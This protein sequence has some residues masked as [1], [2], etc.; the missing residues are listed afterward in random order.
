MGG[1]E[2]IWNSS[3]NMQF[4]FLNASL[5]QPT[6]KRSKKEKKENIF[7]SKI[8]ESNPV[9]D[10]GGFHHL[11]VSTEFDQPHGG[12]GGRGLSFHLHGLRSG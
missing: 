11:L 3:E 10:V 12:S 5:R 1:S 4:C 8:S 9:D 7:C 2:E 6:G